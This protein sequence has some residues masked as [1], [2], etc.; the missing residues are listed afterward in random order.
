VPIA[1]VEEQTDLDFGNLKDFD[2][3]A[4]T[5]G[6]PVRRLQSLADIVL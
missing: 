5:E 6:S 2:P 4:Q 3:L 1:T